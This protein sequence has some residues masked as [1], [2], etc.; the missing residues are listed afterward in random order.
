MSSRHF[1]LAIFYISHCTFIGCTFLGW[2][3]GAHAHWREA[4]LLQPSTECRIRSGTVNPC[5]FT[6]VPPTWGSLATL[7]QSWAS[8]SFGL[9]KV[10]FL[11]D[12]RGLPSWSTLR[13]QLKL[14]VHLLPS[15]FHNPTITLQLLVPLEYPWIFKTSPL[16]F[17]CVLFPFFVS[18]PRPMNAKKTDTGTARTL[19]S[20][21]A[22][23]KWWSLFF[24]TVLPRSGP[25]ATG[26]CFTACSVARMTT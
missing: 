13:T 17:W 10:L 8:A 9:R 4:A 14:G 21:H 12:Q 25:R 1:F 23:A 11:Q 22:V 5:F 6:M 24:I 2:E 20:D 19:I 3:C 7:Q 18:L 16:S 15:C 26:K